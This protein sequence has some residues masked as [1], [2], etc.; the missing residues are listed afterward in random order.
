MQ[1]LGDDRAGSGKA[2]R[3]PA[4]VY[5]HGVRARNGESC[6][7][8]IRMRRALTLI[9][10]ET[11]NESRVS[12]RFLPRAFSCVT[13]G[14]HHKPPLSSISRFRMR[15]GGIEDAGRHRM[16]HM[17]YVLTEARL[18]WQSK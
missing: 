17:L 9:P 11:Y 15:L 2:H 16:P 13:P 6:R 10:H 12:A 8:A 3:G 14:I 7:N 1:I 4:P 5:P 18:G